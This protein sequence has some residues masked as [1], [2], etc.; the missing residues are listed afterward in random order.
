MT[1]CDAT[2]RS[3]IAGAV[4]IASAISRLSWPTY[5]WASTS[6]VCKAAGLGQRVIDTDGRR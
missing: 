3:Y 1:A 2:T 4:S 5:W 6:E